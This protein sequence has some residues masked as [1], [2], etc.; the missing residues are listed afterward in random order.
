LGRSER[1]AA[2][3]QRSRHRI[4]STDWF[5]NRDSEIKRLTRRI[6]ELLAADP[7][8]QAQTEK[9]RK[10]DS[11]REQ[12]VTLWQKEIKA[13]FPD[14][15]E[16]SGLFGNGLLDELLEKRPKNR[17]EWFRKIPHSI[18]VSIDSKQVAKYLDRVLDI[19][20]EHDG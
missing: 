10:L 12:L 18:R 2:S 8:Y 15:P 4:W 9:S 7:Y 14:S 5:K 1:C 6:G 3:Q 20:A 16:T 17:D 19:I 13:D 11:L